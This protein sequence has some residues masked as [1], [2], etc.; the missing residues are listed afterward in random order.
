LSL[1][2]LEQFCKQQ[3]KNAIYLGDK[4]N[5]YINYLDTILDIYPNA[6]YLAIIKEGRDI[7]SSYKNLS[8]IGISFARTKVIKL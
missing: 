3:Y 7:A 2:V 5:Y 6:K 4:N 8:N 1:G